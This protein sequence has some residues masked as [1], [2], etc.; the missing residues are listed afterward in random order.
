[1]FKFTFLHQMT[2]LHQAAEEGD[3]MQVQYLIEKGADVNNKDNTL[4]V[5][6]Y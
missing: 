3:L 1:M 4:G 5:K 6:I 2:P